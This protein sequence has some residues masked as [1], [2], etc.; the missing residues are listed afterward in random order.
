MNIE[1]FF[2]ERLSPSA[3]FTTRP[4][5]CPST[6]REEVRQAASLGLRSFPV[7]QL[8]R[9]TANPNLLIGEAT[10]DISRLE[11]LAAAYEPC[12]WRVVADPCLCV[13]RIDGKDGMDSVGELSKFDQEECFTP[14]AS[15]GNTVWNFF[16]RPNGLALRASAKVKELAPG[17]SVVPEG[18]SCP[19]PSSTGYA[20]EISAVPYWLKELAFEAPDNPPGKA[21]PVPAPSTRP[22]SCRQRSPKPSLRPSP[23]RPIARF[24]HP[25]QGMRKGY[26]VH[27]QAGWRGGFRVSRRR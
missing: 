1:H 2:S 14:Q 8:A 5:K 19:V 16:R 9:L 18:E 17:V 20:L 13:L 11:E 12:E 24:L 6:L 10:C 25:G 26:P 4:G 23:C 22:V 21:A 3:D 7:S 15:R 27:S